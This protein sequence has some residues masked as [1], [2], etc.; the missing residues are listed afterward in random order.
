MLLISGS[1][2]NLE[3]CH[4]CII[5]SVYL[6]RMSSTCVLKYA[7][8]SF[9]WYS[10]C[11]F[12]IS[13]VTSTSMQTR[14]CDVSVFGDLGFCQ[15]FVCC[16]FIAMWLQRD[17]YSFWRCSV[18]M[19]CR[20]GYALSIHASVCNYGVPY[21]DQSCSTFAIKCLLL[22]LIRSWSFVIFVAIDV[23]ILWA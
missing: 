3:I 9:Q 5:Y 15:V 7:M 2:Q 12:V 4:F 20:Y 18:R 22:L 8:P 11:I 14:L 1:Y 16:Y 10:P 17:P 19:F 6:L 21:H 23:C 13:M